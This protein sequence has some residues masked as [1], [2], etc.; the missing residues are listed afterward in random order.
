MLHGAHLHG[1]V[2]DSASAHLCLV[3]VMQRVRLGAETASGYNRQPCALVA[4]E[5]RCA[6]LGRAQQ[7]PR[8]PLHHCVLSTL[9]CHQLF[10]ALI[11]GNNKRLLWDPALSTNVLTTSTIATEPEEHSAETTTVEP[12]RSVEAIALTCSFIRTTAS[13]SV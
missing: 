5:N 9:A 8:G 7:E 11:G 6:A 10:R 2:R 4:A 12:G 3:H 1:V 13:I